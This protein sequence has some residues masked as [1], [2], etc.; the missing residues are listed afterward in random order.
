MS[1]LTVGAVHGAP[2]RYNLELN[3]YSKDVDATGKEI[4][5]MTYFFRMFLQINPEDC[6]KIEEISQH[7][8]LAGAKTKFESKS[9]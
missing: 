7:R 2:Y 6:C 8:W 1:R 9:L 4:A 3:V 5:A